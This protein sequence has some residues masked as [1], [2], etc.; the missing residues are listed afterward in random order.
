[1]T[2]SARRAPFF[3]LGSLLVLASVFGVSS[4]AQ[5]HNYLLSSIPAADSTL[6]TLPDAFEITTNDSLLSLSGAA[7][8]FAL[9]VRDGAGLYYGNGCVDVAGPS[10]T[11]PAELG[12]PGTYTVTWQVVSVDGHPVSDSYNF[13]WAPAAG[14]TVSA[15]STVAPVCG[16]VRPSAGGAVGPSAGSAVG[17]PADAPSATP[18]PAKDDS[19]SDIIWIGG[20]VVALAAIVVGILVVTGRKGAKKV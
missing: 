3:L 15:G 11:T 14:Q 10:M 9:Q 6:T 7:A 2:R 18:P 13:T 4:S 20:G 12:A 19:L 1:M 5:A 16:A 17:P 8:S